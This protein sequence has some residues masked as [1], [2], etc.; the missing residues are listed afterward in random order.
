MKKRFSTRRI[1]FDLSTKFA[2]DSRDI[3]LAKCC[4]NV[5]IKNDKMICANGAVR[6]NWTQDIQL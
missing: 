5:K 1:N 3:G 4:Y 6:F 2:G